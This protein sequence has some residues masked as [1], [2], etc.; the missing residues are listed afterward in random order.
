MAGSAVKKERPAFNPD[1]LRWAREWRGRTTEQA[2]RKLKRSIAEIEAWEANRGA[3]TVSQARILADFYDRHF[4]EFFL[5]ERP[6]IPSPEL[7]ADYRMHAGVSPPTDNREL[8]AI[9]QWAETQRINALDLFEEI[10]EKPAVIPTTLFA[11]VENDPEIAAAAARDAVSFPVQEQIKL[12]NSQADSLPNIIRKKFEAI[13]ILT[14]RRAGLKKHGIRGICIA[15]FPLPVIVFRD[16][17]PSA[18][19]FTLAHELGHVLLE[20]SAFTGFRNP[21]YSRNPVEEWCDK[22]AASFLV[23]AERVKEIAGVK[24]IRPAASFDDEE[25]DR[26]ADIFRVSPH[27]MLIRLVQIGYVEAA[28]YWNVKK[29]QF[30]ETDEHFRRFGRTKYYGSRYRNS[31]GDLY[32]G[33]VLEAWASGRITNHAAAQYMGIKNISHLLDIREQYRMS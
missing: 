33:L 2:A 21:E 4:L 23:P 5:P 1:M 15:E 12:T 22:F 9:Q 30:D 18:Q 32:T 11:T 31:L 7:V 26:I 14:L 3:P 19:A 25:L 16:E 27:A 29:P 20:E 24:P 17:A 13:G 28:Y 10:G 6:D 8:Q